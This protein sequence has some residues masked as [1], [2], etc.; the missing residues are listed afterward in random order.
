MVVVE[1]KPIRNINVVPFNET[2]HQLL[3]ARDGVYGC[4]TQ[5]RMG[6]LGHDGYHVKRDCGVVIDKTLSCA[7]LG[8]PVPCPT[9]TGEFSHPDQ[10]RDG[11]QWPKLRAGADSAGPRVGQGGATRPHGWD[12]G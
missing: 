1:I 9:P 12:W 2:I 5:I 8:Y 10:W 11:R 6:D 3:K 4:H 7:I